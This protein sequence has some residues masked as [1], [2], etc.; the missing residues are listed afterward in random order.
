MTEPRDLEEPGEFDDA[1]KALDEQIDGGA[2]IDAAIEAVDQ[3]E[4]VKALEAV[5][6]LVADFEWQDGTKMKLM[7]PIEFDA[8]KFETAVGILMQL[9]LAAEQRKAALNPIIVPPETF[10][11]RPDGRRLT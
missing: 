10:L 11:V 7:V 2:Q 8:D 4:A 5:E 3:A 6:T 9:R 1:R